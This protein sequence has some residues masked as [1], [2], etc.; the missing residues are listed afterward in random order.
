MNAA[1][2]AHAAASQRGPQATALA[3]G[4][5]ALFVGTRY[6]LVCLDEAREFH[7][8]LG[9]VIAAAEAHPEMPS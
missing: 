7:H 5:I 9:Q 4:R 1:A 3:D 6:S 8:R 2:P